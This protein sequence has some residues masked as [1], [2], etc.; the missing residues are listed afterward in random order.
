MK[1]NNKMYDVSTELDNVFGAPGT[2]SRREAEDLAWQEYNAQILLDAR[3][4]AGLT[5]EA[6]A[7]RIGVSKGYISRIERGITTPT[8]STFYRIVAAMGLVVELR[9]V[10]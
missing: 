1:A 8:I 7:E 3:K 6:L 10:L 4:N 2:E 9:P 5:Q